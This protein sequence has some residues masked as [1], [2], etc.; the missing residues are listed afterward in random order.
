[1]PSQPPSFSPTRVIAPRHIPREADRQRTRALN[2]NSAEWKR[3]RQFVLVRDGY[4]CR[5]CGKLVVGREA[6][7]DHIDG[8]SH[9]NAPDGSNWQTLCMYGHSRKTFAEQRGVAWDGVCDPRGR[10]KSP[11][12]APS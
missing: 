12:D 9:H 10:V 2:T 6:H 7:V 1:M 8:D 5:G 11:E 3:I 4:R